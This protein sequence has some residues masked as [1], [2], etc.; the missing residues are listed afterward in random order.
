MFEQELIA[1]LGINAKPRAWQKL[2][3]RLKSEF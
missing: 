3:T 2:M 1:L